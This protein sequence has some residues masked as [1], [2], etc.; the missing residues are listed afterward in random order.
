MQLISS[1][2]CQCVC[3]GVAFK[4]SFEELMVVKGAGG[5]GHGYRSAG[6]MSDAYPHYEDEWAVPKVEKSNWAATNRLMC[7]KRCVK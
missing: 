3:H 5:S 6:T 1:A 7:R 4:E 2:T